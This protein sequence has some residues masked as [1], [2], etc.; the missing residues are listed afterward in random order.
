MI[1]CRNEVRKWQTVPIAGLRVSGASH[2]RYQL[3]PP[4][5]VSRL[6][7]WS[8]QFV[9]SGIAL[10]VGRSVLSETL[11]G[12]YCASVGRSRC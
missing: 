7:P 11:F 3:R 8:T 5:C 12:Y 2:V 10:E 1:K 9:M 6:S 4:P